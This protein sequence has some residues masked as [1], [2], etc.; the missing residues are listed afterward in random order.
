MKTSNKIFI[1]FLIFLLVGITSLYIGSKYYGN[2]YDDPANFVKQEKPLPPFSVVVAEPS[3]I[4]SLKSEKENKITQTYLKNTLPDIG[5]CL[6]R[7]DTLFISS[8]QLKKGQVRHTSNLTYISCVKVKSI[9]IKE[10]SNVRMEKFQADTLSVIMNKSNLHFRF[11]N[12]ASA[13]INAISSIVVLEGKNLK[14]IDLQLDEQ[15]TINIE[16]REGVQSISGSIK[17]KSYVDFSLNGKMSLDIDKSSRVYLK[18]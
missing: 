7:N 11:E 18:N 8:I 14:K 17:N 3:T 10:N 2:L 12:I 1:T 5:S 15:T 4:F 6:V 16:T 13:R 9:I